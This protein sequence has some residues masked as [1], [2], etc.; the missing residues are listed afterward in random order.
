MDN[1]GQKIKTLR[2][3]RGLNVSKFANALGVSHVS[4][5]NWEKGETQNMKLESLIALSK[6]FSLSLDDL[7]YGDVSES[8]AQEP[9]STTFDV[10]DIR[11]ACGNGLINSEYPEVIKRL[12]M[13]IE[14]AQEIIG[15]M[16]Q[17]GN[18]K[19]IIAAKDS[20]VPT[21]NPNDLLFIDISVQQFI[22]EAVYIL[23]H[24]GELLCKRLSLIGK[25]LTVISDNK[26]Y[27][28]WLW[29]DKPDE[30]RIIGKVLRALPMN[31]KN[32]GN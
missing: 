5:L 30:T 7:I 24:G 19:V 17:S 29:N 8:N 13:P 15:N 31:F 11:A 1:L 25:N 22:G 9:T 23:L 28:S 26:N 4:V 2:E 27:E 20:M 12:V 6:F 18:I 14:K 3:A 16:N 10:L 21:I 32:F